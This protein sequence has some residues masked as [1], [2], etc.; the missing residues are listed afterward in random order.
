MNNGGRAPSGG[1]LLATLAACRGAPLQSPRKKLARKKN[2]CPKRPGP[3]QK[4]C[5]ALSHHCSN[6][7][8]SSTAPPAPPRV[9]LRCLAPRVWSLCAQHVCCFQWRRRSLSGGWK[10]V[11]AQTTRHPCILAG[12]HGPLMLPPPRWAKNKSL[13]VVAPPATFAN[14][15]KESSSPVRSP[16]TARGVV[17]WGAMSGAD[18]Q[19]GRREGCARARCCERRES[20]NK[21]NT[22]ASQAQHTHPPL[23]PPPAGGA[24]L[25][26]RSSLS[27]APPPSGRLHWGGSGACVPPP[28]A[29]ASAAG[30]QPAAPSGAVRPQ[31][32]PARCPAGCDLHCE[33]PA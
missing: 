24:H 22:V 26:I 30:A 32:A 16:L 4:K 15:N 1:L 2:G 21:T 23:G 12:K 8:S 10:A 28:G 17:G 18:Q 19:G 11:F 14:R 27:L 29:L 13:V 3:F 6:S 25:A 5:P 20:S 31:Q 9:L 7:S 33:G